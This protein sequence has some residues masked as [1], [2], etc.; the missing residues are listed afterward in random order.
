MLLG[1]T[2]KRWRAAWENVAKTAFFMRN[3]CNSLG[4][5]S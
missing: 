3:S 5:R 4:A 1:A 2:I